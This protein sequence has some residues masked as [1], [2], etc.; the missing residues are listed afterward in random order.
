LPARARALQAARRGMGV[1]LGRRVA[2]AGCRR[3]H[4]MQRRFRASPCDQNLREAGADDDGVERGGLHTHV[5]HACAGAQARPAAA[6]WHAWRCAPH[7]AGGNQRP[8]LITLR[9]LIQRLWNST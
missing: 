9:V 2:A 6:V 3:P 1:A 4:A 8:G 5:V 7:A